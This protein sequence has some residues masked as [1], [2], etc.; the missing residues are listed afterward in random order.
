MS[1]ANATTPRVFIALHGE[2]EWAVSGLC[3]GNAEFPLTE[4]GENQSRATGEKLVGRGKLIDP[5]KLAHDF[6]SPHQRAI[7]TLDLLLGGTRKRV[8]SLRQSSALRTTSLSGTMAPTKEGI[9]PAHIKAQRTEKGLPKWDIWTMGYPGGG[10]PSQVQ[11]RLDRLIGN[12]KKIQEPFMHGGPAPDVLIVAHGHI[13]RAFIKRWLEWDMAF[14]FTM[15][16]EPGAIDVL[17]YAH[18]NLSEPSVLI[19]MAFPTTG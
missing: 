12:I 9:T 10:S 14:P 13:I 17:S 19:G 8:W 4:N 18:H 7:K 1:D 6:C 5:A 2:T 16:M 3:T 11:E 15:M